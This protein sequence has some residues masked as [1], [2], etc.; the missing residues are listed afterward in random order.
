[1]LKKYCALL[2]IMC[3]TV[4]LF[5]SCRSQ[6]KT[7]TFEGTYLY[8]LPTIDD[9]YFAI[10]S[11]ASTVFPHGTRENHNCRF[12]SGFRGGIIFAPQDF[13]GRQF[14]GYYT[15]LS[16][17]QTKTVKGDFLWATLGHPD[18]ASSFENYAGEA[19]ARFDF[20]YQRGDILF[21]QKLFRC[22]KMDFYFQGGAEFASIHF[23]EDYTYTSATDL[24]LIKQKSKTWGVG[25]Q[26]GIE[27]DYA[28]YHFNFCCPGDLSFV[29][30][31]SGSLLAA[32]THAE[33][34]DT[35]DGSRIVDI[36]DKN[37]CR[38]IPAWHAR[39]GFNYAARVCGFAGAVEVG[40]EMNSYSRALSRVLFS[41]DVA[42]SLSNNEY[43]NFDAQGLYVTVSL[44][45]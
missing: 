33:V 10:K 41:D 39:F 6:A 19:S 1:M 12:H 45:F 44:S 9:S 32:K 14:R 4:S 28:I 42:D 37:A 31:A 17:N 5:A 24:G 7:W 22:K 20:L 36:K 27:F 11:P 21:S 30:L 3:C 43:F 35:L 16:T 40:Y 2:L 25:P 15:R 34:L 38:I 8:L 29:A 13:C 18:L 23:H 26:M